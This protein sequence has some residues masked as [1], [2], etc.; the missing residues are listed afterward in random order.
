MEWTKQTYNQQYEKWVPWLEDL[1]LRYFTKDN[2]ASYAAKE[3][4]DK[5][6][7]THIPQIDALQDGVNNLAAGQLGQGGL[8]QPIGD[9]ASREGLT[10]AERQGRDDKGQYVSDSAAAGPVAS[11]GNTVVGGVASGVASGGRQVAEGVQGG[12]EV[13]GGILGLGGK[14]GERK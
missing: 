14:E 13:A 1:Y 8:G 12:L 9:M 3:E 11:A 5:T 7:V 10:R 2:K 6:K 4:L